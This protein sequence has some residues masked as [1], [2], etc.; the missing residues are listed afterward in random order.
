M[1][2]QQNQQKCQLPTKCPP[3]G[4]PQGSPAP[5]PCLPPNAPPAPACCVSTCYIS[6]FGGSCSLVSHRF[7]RFYLRQP[8]RSEHPENE[9]AGCASCPHS[10]G[11]CS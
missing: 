4:P 1:S 6:G 8:Q 10:S 7:P 11:N 2:S 9:S 5:A 3:K